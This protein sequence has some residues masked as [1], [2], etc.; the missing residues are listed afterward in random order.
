MKKELFESRIRILLHP[1]IF[2]THAYLLEKV[3]NLCYDYT[4]MHVIYDYCHK[5]L[6]SDLFSPFSPFNEEDIWVLI[7]SIVGAYNFLHGIGLK[8]GNLKF[9]TIYQVKS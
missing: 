4:N 2:Q 1:N 7:D 3:K 6:Q 8:H 5:T 9:S